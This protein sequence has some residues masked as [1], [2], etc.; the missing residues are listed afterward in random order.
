M[1]S[2]LNLDV[3]DLCIL[4]DTLWAGVKE[5]Q[6]TVKKDRSATDVPFWDR[7][8]P[9]Y[10]FSGLMKCGCCGGGYSKIS[11]DAFG[12]STARNKGTCDNRLNIRRDVLEATVLD[13]LR[14]HLM[15]PD[16]FEVF[17][18]EFTQELNRLR[19]T[20]GVDRKV[21]EQEL[22][23]VRN[24][25]KRLIEAIKSGVPA[26]SIKDE[27]TELE[28]RKQVLTRSLDN[29]PEEEPLL[30]PSM[31]LIYRQKV[32]DL[33][34]ALHEEATSTK[35][36]ELIRSLVDE[37]RLVPVEGE[38]KIELKGDLAAILGLCQTSK[39]P[40]GLT[41]ER[42]LQVMLVAGARNN[43]EPTLTIFI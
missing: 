25:I 35:A 36:F 30:L 20:E 34:A 24:N 28:D 41:P 42:L 19:M 22:E 43:Q 8:R 16:L 12:C 21:K 37:I 32:A 11:K 33:Q 38:L 31:A 14:H 4:S 2:W 7:R 15:D 1:T 5:R 10:L 23:K 26:L 40:S 27:L 3:P 17:C 6:L 29:M 13:G 9:R 18:T 39:S